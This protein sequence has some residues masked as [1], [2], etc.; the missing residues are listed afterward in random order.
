VYRSTRMA[1]TS[2]HTTTEERFDREHSQKSMARQR[3]SKSHSDAKIDRRDKA[4]DR[5]REVVPAIISATTRRRLRG[6]A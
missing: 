3:N 2:V 1:S 6:R 5:R 4:L